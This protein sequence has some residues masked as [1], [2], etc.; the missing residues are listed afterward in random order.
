MRRF[1]PSPPA[2]R[3]HN[4]QAE[5]HLVRVEEGD[6]EEDDEAGQEVVALV[7]HQVVHKTVE[8]PVGIL[9]IGNLEPAKEQ[10]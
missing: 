8:P 4:G 2:Q 6:G 1:L 3:Y 10:T 7:V 5:H 9:D